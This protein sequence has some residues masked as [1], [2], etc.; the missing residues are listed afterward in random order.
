MSVVVV[1]KERVRVAPVFVRVAM[2]LRMDPSPKLGG[3]ESRCRRL[4]QKGRNTRIA[5]HVPM[6]RDHVWTS[7]R[8]KLF[9]HLALKSN[10]KAQRR[11]GDETAD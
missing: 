7:I 8:C 5:D 4:V 3:R 2:C 1:A 10:C 9:C 6:I 11:A